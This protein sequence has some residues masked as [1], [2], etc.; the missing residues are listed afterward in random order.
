MKE[1]DRGT[2]KAGSATEAYCRRCYRLGV[3]TEP[4]MTV[5]EMRET[6]RRK[7]LEMHFPR[8]LAILMANRVYTLR[9]WAG[10]RA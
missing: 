8:F 5:D 3:F 2:D 9:R 1:T 6:I 4:Q 10:V 7:M